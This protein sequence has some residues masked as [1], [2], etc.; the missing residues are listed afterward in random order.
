MERLMA[1]TK[2]QLDKIYNRTSGYC[3]ICHKKL[4][5]KN[6]GVFGAR[7]AWEVEHS[8]P[9]IKGGTHHPNNLYPAC[10]SCNRSKGDSSTASV[11]A[12]NGKTCAPLS[13]GQREKAKTEN[14]VLGGVV[15][16]ILGVV[17]GPAGL[18][19]GTI[20][21]AALGYSQNPDK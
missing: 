20:F 19:L 9:Q 5:F 3:H 8:N 17:A 13:V 14:S 10:I 21:G 2:E 11:R 15:G 1:F 12:K 7:A 18:I 16:A 6:Y 4:A